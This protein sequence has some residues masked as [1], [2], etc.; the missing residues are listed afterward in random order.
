MVVSK[1]FEERA[2]L[3]SS[4]LEGRILRIEEQSADKSYQRYAAVQKSNGVALF[5]MTS[6]GLA[7]LHILPQKVEQPAERFLIVIVLLV[8]FDDDLKR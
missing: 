4:L 7:V 2:Q 3:F 6:D 8:A 5:A 1:A